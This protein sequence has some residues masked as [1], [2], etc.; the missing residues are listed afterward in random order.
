[1]KTFDYIGFI[2][3]LIVFGLTACNISGSVESPDILENGPFIYSLEGEI[4]SEI[5]SDDYD[6][7]TEWR[8]IESGLLNEVQTVFFAS[9]R[10]TLNGIDR[11][12]RYI[13]TIVKYDNWPQKGEYSVSDIQSVRDGSTD[14]FFVNLLSM[15]R[16]QSIDENQE[17]HYYLDDIIFHAV[18]GSIQ[19]TTSTTDAFRGSFNLSFD[20]NERRTWDTVE[21]VVEGEL[22]NGLSIQGAFDIDLSAS[23]V[24]KLSNF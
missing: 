14:N 21:E 3:V 6:L 24:E 4:N 13:I 9:T 19:I 22:K 12:Q 15:Y 10:D 16:E 7:L 11:W 5:S 2:Y 8:K 1:M 20:R 18:S 23:R 17:E